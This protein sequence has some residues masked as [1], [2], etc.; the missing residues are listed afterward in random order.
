MHE[1]HYGPLLIVH[2]IIAVS[3]QQKQIE[4]CEPEKSIVVLNVKSKVLALIGKLPD[5]FCELDASG[6][7]AK[8]KWTFGGLPYVAKRCSLRQFIRA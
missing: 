3:N 7:T 6:W 4:G 2:H 1:L 5:V 8:P